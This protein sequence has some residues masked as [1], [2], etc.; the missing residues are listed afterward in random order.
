MYINP[1]TNFYLPICVETRLEFFIDKLVDHEEWILSGHKTHSSLHP[2]RL[3]WKAEQLSS[4]IFKCVE[5]DSKHLPKDMCSH[6]HFSSKECHI[7]VFAKYYKEGVNKVFL[8]FLRAITKLLVKK[9]YYIIYNS[10]LYFCNARHFDITMCM[11]LHLHPKCLCK[12][13]EDVM[14]YMAH[15]HGEWLEGMEEYGRV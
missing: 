13:M 7:E 4:T 3:C 14:D 1:E 6:C 12:E 9:V 15:R 10:A 11:M 8:K 2:I 5:V